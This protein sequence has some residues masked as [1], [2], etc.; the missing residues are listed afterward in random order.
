VAEEYPVVLAEPSDLEALVLLY[1]MV[2]AEGRWIAGEVPI[3]RDERLARWR[4]SL[5]DPSAAQLLARDDQGNLIGS[6]GLTVQRGIAD[7]GMLVHPGWRGRGVG[8][9][10]LRRAI[11]WARDQGA[12]KMVLT[13]WPHN[14]TARALYRKF[15][16][17]DEALLR[18]H[19][20]RRNGEL[21]DAVAMGLV[22]DTES[23]GCPYS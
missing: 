16:F 6:L 1:E 10:L 23:P 19:Y 17:E 9:A 22:L 2:A 7:L 21:W 18:R 13:V 4:R 15:G 11:G 20:R 14:L 8:S 12:H 3:D 5:D